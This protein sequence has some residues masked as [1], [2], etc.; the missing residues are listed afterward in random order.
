ML[1]FLIGVRILI[2]THNIKIGFQYPGSHASSGGSTKELTEKYF[3]EININT[4]RKLYRLYK[5]DFEMF[6]YSPEEYLKLTK[7]Q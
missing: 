2:L 6:G 4:A 5:V 7:T 3:T 1:H